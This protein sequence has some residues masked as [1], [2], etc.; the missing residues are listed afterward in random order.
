[1]WDGREVRLPGNFGPEP[2]SLHGLG[3]QRPWEV[4][5]KARFKCS[6]A[7]SHD[8]SGAWPWA[9]DA[10]QRVRLGVQGLA[11][12]LDVTNRADSAMPC[13]LGLHPYLRRRRETQVAF[14][15]D[16]MLEVDEGLIPTARRPRPAHGP[17]GAPC[18]RARS[19]IA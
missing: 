11:I 19:T 8:G 7:H 3:W 1:M 5:R 13:G 2:H 18:P 14:V 4:T 6:L 16:A 15:A 9:Y 10:E 12:T 17:R